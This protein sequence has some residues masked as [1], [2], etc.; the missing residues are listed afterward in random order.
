MLYKR[1]KERKKE[2]RKYSLHK[3][4]QRLIIYNITELERYLSIAKL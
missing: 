2:R 4:D 3:S 1:K